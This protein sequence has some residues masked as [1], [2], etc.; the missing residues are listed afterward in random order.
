[1]K[2]LIKVFVLISLLLAALT[3][4]GSANEV[5]LDAGDNGSQ[6]ELKSDQ[7]LVISLEGNPTTGYTWEV[8]ELDEGVLKQVGETEFEAESDAVGSG[9]VQTLRFETVNSGQTDLELVYH[10]SWEE[11]EQP[12][13]TFSI[14]VVVR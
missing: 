6:V 11:D 12:V 2:K 5:K 4:C 7:T 3:A 13:D 8:A 9:G 14:Q 10:R 1:M